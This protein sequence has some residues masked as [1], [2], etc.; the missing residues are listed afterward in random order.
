MPPVY[1]S[2]AGSAADHQSSTT[3]LSTAQALKE[4][5]SIH[6]VLDEIKAHVAADPSCASVP[7]SMFEWLNSSPLLSQDVLA[8]PL[9][10]WKQLL[11]K[12]V[13]KAGLSSY[14][15]APHWW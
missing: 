2:T 10:T 15:S 14:S 7:Q 12:Q 6:K 3:M 1:C 8:S 9:A 11:K 5:D 13:S 4:W